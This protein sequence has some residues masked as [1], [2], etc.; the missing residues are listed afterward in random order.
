MGLTDYFSPSTWAQDNASDSDLGSQGPTIVG[1]WVFADGK[2]GTAYVLRRNALGHIG[3][4]VSQASVCRS[5]GGTAVSGDVVFV[6]CIDGLRAVR[7]DSAGAMHI[8]WHTN[9]NITGSPVYGGGRV[10]SLD[11]GAGVLYALDPNTGAVHEQVAVGSV[12]RFATP[13]IY[14]PDLRIP[15]LSGVTIVRTS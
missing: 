14:G 3:G 12:S 13:A 8:L 10:W 6:P 9:S 2:S 1:P 15:T 5:F 4:Q 11:T 7:I